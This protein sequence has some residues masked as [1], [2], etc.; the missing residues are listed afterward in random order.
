[1]D[2][3]EEMVQALRP[4]LA[5]LDRLGVRACVG[6]SIASSVHGAARGTMDV[7]LAAELTVETAL[8]LANTLR[9][10]YYVSRD[11]ALEAV[12]RKSCFNLIHLAT[13]FKIDIFVSK[14][15]GFDLSVFDR[16]RVDSLG[17]ANPLPARI[18]SAED[19]ILIKFEGYRLG[20]ETS[21]RHWSDV[22][23]VAKLHELRLDRSYL[24]HWASELSVADLLDRLFSQIDAG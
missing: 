15:R 5:E 23:R 6:G 17:T 7:D 24:R 3:A 21:E 12:R 16:A 11:A 19:I 18:V 10:E 22:T 1:M 2:N 14:R 8:E 4:V 9:A 20:N 13:S